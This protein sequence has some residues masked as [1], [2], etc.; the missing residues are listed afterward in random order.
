VSRER[1]KNSQWIDARPGD[2]FGHFVLVSLVDVVKARGQRWR[3]RCD[4]GRELDRLLAQL[5]WGS[6]R[7]KP[8]C[9]RCGQRQRVIN[10]GARRAGLA[11]IAA[12]YGD[13]TAFSA[14]DAEG[15][16]SSPPGLEPP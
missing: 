9:A 10:G 5:R 3:V 13:R 12:Q 1:Q 4:C 6:K 16:E 7:G 8:Q 14:V 15:D 11:S 2:R